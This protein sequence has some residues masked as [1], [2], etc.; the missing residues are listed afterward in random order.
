MTTND[1]AKANQRERWLH[2]YAIGDPSWD[3]F[4]RESGNPI[5]QGKPP[6]EWPVNGF[7]FRDPPSG[8]WYAY[9]GLY[10][11]GYWPGGPCLVMR[12]HDGGGWEELDLA[13][14]GDAT[15]FDGDGTHPGG[16]PDVSVVYADGR[17]HM[18]YDW[19][20]YANT[21]GGLAYAWADRPEGP[22]HRAASPIHEDTFQEPILGC[23]VR[24]YA[25]TLIQREHDW[26]IMHDMSTP[27]NAG[28]TWA[29]AC[30]T[31]PNPEGPYSSP[32]LLLYPQTDRYLPPYMEYY[33]AFAHDGYLYAPATSV[34]L[35]RNYQCMF[36]APIEQA[37]QPD[38]WEV[39]QHGSVWHAESDPS[40]AQGIWGQTFSAQV[41]P[42]GIMRVY[43][44]SKTRD[45]TGTVHLARRSW[46]QPYHDGFVLSA[47]NAAALA[48]LRGDI[49]E[50]TS[51]VN[52]SANGAWALCWQCRGPLGPDTAGWNP[53]AHP[54][55]RTQRMEVQL[56]AAEWRIVSIDA[57]GHTQSLDCGP[58]DTSPELQVEI[59]QQASHVTLSLNGVLVSTQNTPAEMGR[60]ELVAQAGTRLQVN[61]FEVE[62]DLTSGSEFLL[63]TEAIAGAGT[64][65]HTQDWQP[66]Q[67][68]HFRFGTGFRNVS[69]AARAK[70]NYYGAGFKL[71]APYSSAY[72]KARVIADGKP[73][74]TIDLHAE[75]DL[76]SCVIFEATL[77]VGFHAVAI[78]PVNGGVIPCD[79]LEITQP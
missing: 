32:T 15:M 76:P 27:G 61:A 6:Y 57:Q 59:R 68:E 49:G 56:D 78:E 45:D 8:R 7:L 64:G 39:A 66:V 29:L 5:Y 4:V 19:A 50:F 1:Y 63:A 2:H 77:P 46:N 35:N 40:E 12:E 44:N 23:Y 37:H 48:V 34:A 10:P 13:I 79:C 67:H 60:L 9:V 72:T 14:Q 11:R 73:M 71:Y 52:A 51:R 55:M 42:E 3:T 36:R 41:S 47:P 53:Q 22:F 16:M 20:N 75:M 65:I 62:G 58:R 18:V 28:G 21:R 31:A 74:A 70:W 30:M 54:L 33:P 26:I 43:F 38:A 69:D 25:A 17:Y 24:T